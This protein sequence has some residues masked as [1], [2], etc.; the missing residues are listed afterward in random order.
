[1]EKD[2]S[3]AV[4]N[5]HMLPAKK[6]NDQIICSADACHLRLLFLRNMNGHNTIN[7]CLDLLCDWYMSGIGK[8]KYNGFDGGD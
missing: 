5:D 7:Q 2:L 1:M 6:T 3:T 8:G 4:T